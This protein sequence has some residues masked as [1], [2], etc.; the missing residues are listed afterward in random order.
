MAK[1]LIRLFLIF[2]FTVLIVTLQ[3]VWSLLGSTTLGVMD[4]MGW[5]FYV[6]SAISHT[7]CLAI[8]GL[9]LAMVVSR[10]RIVSIVLQVVYGVLLSSVVWINAQVYL[11]YRFHING[12]ILNMLTGPAAGQIFQFDWRLVMS[13]V[14]VILLI[15][16]I[17]IGA[18][19]ISNRFCKSQ[20]WRTVVAGICA[21]V[22][23]TLFAHGY[24]IYSSFFQKTSVVASAKLLPYYFPTTA[25]RLMTEKFGFEAPTV[26]TL[27]LSDGAGSQLNYPRQELVVEPKSDKLNIL[28]I[29]VDSWNRRAFTPE[30][31]PRSYKFAQ[32]NSYYTNHY[33]CSNGT[34][35]SVFGIWFGISSY[36]WDIMD[37]NHQMPLIL[38]EARR[39]G[40]EFHNYPGASEVDP[41][42]GRVLFAKEP[43][44]KL[45][46]PGESV[47]DRDRQITRDFI[48]AS[49]NYTKPFIDFVFYDL[50]HSLDGKLPPQYN[51]FQPAWDYARYTEL[52][53]DMDPTPFWNLYRNTCSACD[54]LLGLIYQYLDECDLGK[55]TVV[56]V[57]GD[58]SQE[59][60]ENHQNFWGHNG[61]FSH[62]QCMVPLIV[63]WP[64]S[65]AGNDS[66][67]GGKVF[68]YRT[69]HYD[70]VPTLMHDVL[71]VQNDPSDYSMGN[72]LSDSISSRDWHVVGSELNYAFILP[73]DT[74]LEKSA[75]GA[76][77][78]TDSL[79]N[80]LTDYHIDP[81]A[82]RK[83]TDKLNSFLK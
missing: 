77:I 58:H 42:F 18:A 46:T 67:A 23:C 7:A 36:Y 61:N 45:E 55:N 52:H 49:R 81:V 1:H 20:T 47:Y 56:I 34:K 83:A 4:T 24:H 31:M 22:V 60:N 57:T 68:N 79:L 82:L 37:S 27:N 69:T 48:S 12:I 32:D 54:D 2:I 59:F 5:L 9:L 63:H 8:P 28:V 66:I 41:P 3:F 51:Q 70:I 74:I 72:L 40:Y 44:F 10:L 73:G 62:H 11:I 25:A 53:N 6:T 15:V 64:E 65:V 29:L 13:V 71:G 21:I 80:P 16:S 76:L 38:E 35:S 43:N 33:G 75:E 26:A 14:T 19:W 17:Y 30:C 39:Q 78:A 50:P